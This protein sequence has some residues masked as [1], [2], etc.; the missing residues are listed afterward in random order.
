MFQFPPS[1][2]SSLWLTLGVIALV[3][4]LTASHVFAGTVWQ[5]MKMCSFDDESVIENQSTTNH[6]P[7][8]NPQSQVDQ[9]K[10]KVPKGGGYLPNNSKP[11]QI[12]SVEHSQP[13]TSQLNSST[14][15]MPICD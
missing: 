15:P 8:S 14:P 5:Q 10:L 2:Q 11:C 12:S 3:F 7:T 9:H 1:Q 6:L 4:L 13:D